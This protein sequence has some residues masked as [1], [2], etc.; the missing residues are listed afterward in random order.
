[1][2]TNW[3]NILLFAAILLV[4]AA[5]NAAFFV[6]VKTHIAIVILWCASSGTIAGFLGGRY[7]KSHG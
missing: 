7:L 4:F 1:M 3:K 5:I 6:H 2:K